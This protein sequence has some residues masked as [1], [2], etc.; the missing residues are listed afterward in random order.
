MALN[1]EDLM[2]ISDI[3]DIT[4]NHDDKDDDTSEA[5][6][7][8]EKNITEND[9]IEMANDFKVRMF[10]K[11][12]TIQNLQKKLILIYALVERYM[13]TDDPAF[14][15]EARLILDK[16]LIDNIGVQDID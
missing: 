9:Y 12:I 3:N 11:N 10:S 13:D 15:E 7:K 4:D 14:I 6:G 5:S 1:I 16:V 8:V 2:D